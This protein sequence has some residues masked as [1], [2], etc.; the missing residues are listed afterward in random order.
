MI[1]ILMAL[2]GL[3]AGGVTALIIQSI[4]P[5]FPYEVALLIGLIVGIAVGLFCEQ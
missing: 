3:I 1:T 5:T 2:M 4:V